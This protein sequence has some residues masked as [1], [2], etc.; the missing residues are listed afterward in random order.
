MEETNDII[1]NKKT[2]IV[3]VILVFIIAIVGIYLLTKE[4]NSSTKSENSNSNSNNKE[5]A[6]STD[7]NNWNGTYKNEDLTITLYRSREDQIEFSISGDIMNPDGT[8]T[9]S[10]TSFSLTLDS[11]ERLENDDSIF[12]TKHS[13]IIIKTDEGISVQSSSS[14]PN[15]LLNA[16][17]GN[18]LKNEFT[19]SNWD[20]VYTNNNTSIILS[21]VSEQELYINI[22]HNFSIHITQFKDYTNNKIIYEDSFFEDIIKINITKVSDGLEIQSSSTDSDSLLNE[23]NGKYTKK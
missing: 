8:T 11:A 12:D 4:S 17:N 21:E 10:S 13:I 19:S 23:I 15:N 22:V 7:Y 1:N 6:K 5:N 14:D 16:A 20:G 2:F 3:G 18:Y 9:S